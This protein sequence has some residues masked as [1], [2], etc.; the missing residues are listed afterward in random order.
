MEKKE[1]SWGVVG[2]LYSA[3]RAVS[4]THTNDVESYE[5]RNTQR[6]AVRATLAAHLSPAYQL[7][8]LLS[9]GVVLGGM[10]SP[11]DPTLTRKY[12]SNLLPNDAD[13]VALAFTPYSKRNANLP[14]ENNTGVDN[15]C[16]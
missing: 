15:Y 11:A 7:P 2:G 8:A 9:D 3:I 14:G 4:L 13:D 6:A 1:K 12:P 10:R 16:F 5:F